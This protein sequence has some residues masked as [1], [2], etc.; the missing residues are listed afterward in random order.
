MLKKTKNTETFQKKGRGSPAAPRLP[1]NIQK[2]SNNRAQ[3]LRPNS[4]TIVVKK[5]QNENQKQDKNPDGANSDPSNPPTGQ[6]SPTRNRCKLCAEIWSVPYPSLFLIDETCNFWNSR[7]MPLDNCRNIQATYGAACGCP[8]PPSPVCNVCPDGDYIWNDSPQYNT[9]TDDF[10][11]KMIYRMSKR[12]EF[13]DGNK[14]R[15]AQ[16]CCKSTCSDLRLQ[17]NFEKEGKDEKGDKKPKSKYRSN[18]S[19][20]LKG[21]KMETSKIKS[22]DIRSFAAADPSNVGNNDEVYHYYYYYDV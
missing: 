10:C 19:Q 4:P 9:F 14:E 20:K 3:R 18:H 16:M 7:E 17:K 11:V 21:G 1:A 15:V 2:N 8:N 6:K 12:T 22:D 13:C 5:R